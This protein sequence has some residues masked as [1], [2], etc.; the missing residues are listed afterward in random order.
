MSRDNNSF[1]EIYK[2]AYQ[3]SSDEELQ[4][5][6]KPEQDKPDM[7]GAFLVQPKVGPREIGE[8]RALESNELS[9]ETDLFR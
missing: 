5:I 9:G 7:I 6:H 4:K 3:E 2:L 1:Y 8:G